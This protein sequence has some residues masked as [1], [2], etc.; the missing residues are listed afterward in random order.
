MDRDVIMVYLWCRVLEVKYLRKEYV[1]CIAAAHSHDAATAR[2]LD[3]MFLGAEVS[4][5]K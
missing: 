2:D 5:P 1:N 3:Q 4:R